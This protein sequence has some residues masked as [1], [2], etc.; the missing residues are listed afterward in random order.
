MD[1]NA[2]VEIGQDSSAVLID[3]EQE[4]SSRREVEANDVLAVGKRK[5]I[6][7]VARKSECK[8]LQSKDIAVFGYRRPTAQDQRPR[9]DCLLARASRCHRE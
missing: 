4:I 5:G 1:C 9:R 3:R 8:Q 2:T 7:G 6:G